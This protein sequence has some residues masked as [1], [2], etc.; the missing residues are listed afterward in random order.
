LLQWKCNNYDMYSECVFVALVIQH[1]VRMRHNVICGLYSC[2]IFIS[3]NLING[4]ISE[5]KKIEH[6]FCVLI[7]STAFV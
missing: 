7:F 2:T 4:T 3:H 1:A 5:K 6:E